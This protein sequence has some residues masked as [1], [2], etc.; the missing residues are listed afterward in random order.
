MTA[1]TTVPAN[2]PMTSVLTPRFIGIVRG[3]IFKL[4][5]QRTTWITLGAVALFIAFSWLQIT[6]NTD[7]KASLQS[8]PLA[9]HLEWME[10]S[11]SVLRIFSGFALIVLTARIIGL[12]Y[13]QG[14]IRIILSRGVDRL[15]LLGAKLVTAGLV[16]LVILVGGIAL[17][18]LFA[19]IIVGSLAGSLSTFSALSGTFWSDAGLYLLSVIISMVATILL[20]TVLT[21]LGRS[22]TFGLAVGL[23]FFPADNISSFILSRVAV[24]TNNDFWNQI[25]AYLLGPALNFLPAVLLPHPLGT[26][27]TREGSTIAPQYA[28]NIG[29]PPSSVYGAGHFLVLIGVYAMACLVIAGLL[30]WRRDVME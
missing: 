7:A 22:L 30:F 24:S 9:F 11:L 25:T 3:E 2:M 19:L 5:R 12:D 13:Q 4:T 14:T 1:T 21:V 26:V 20:A 15:K 29:T 8:N 17:N 10:V 18:A 28:F 23:V 27:V 6:G 16:A